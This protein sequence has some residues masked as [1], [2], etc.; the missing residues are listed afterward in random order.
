MPEQSKKKYRPRRKMVRRKRIV[1]RASNVPEWASISCKETIAPAAGVS[2]TVN[3]LYANMSTCLLQFARASTLSQAFQHFRIKKIAMTFLPQFDTFGASGGTGSKPNLYY[4]IDK[5]GSVAPNISL[6]GL[7]NL[8]ARPIALDEKP[9]T[10]SWAPSVLEGV[11]STPGTV[12]V[13]GRYRISPWL[14][15][16]STVLSPGYVPSQVRH[17]GMYWYVDQAEAS[18]TPYNY[19][20]E[21]EVQFEFKKPNVLGLTTDH[22]AVEVF[23]TTI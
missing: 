18:A 19:K 1:K 4:M 23:T 7:K 22:T 8:G 20:V 6:E 12:L 5:S 15:T 16:D 11:M 9:I 17:L 13:P 3:T 14:S 10:V 2:Y 21:V